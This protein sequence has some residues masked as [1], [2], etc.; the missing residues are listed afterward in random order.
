MGIDDEQS[1]WNGYWK[2]R[3][4]DSFCY[5]DEQEETSVYYLL[6]D[7]CERTDIRREKEIDGVPQESKTAENAQADVQSASKGYEQFEEY[8]CKEMQRKAELAL[9]LARVGHGKPSSE[10]HS[11]GGA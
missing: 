3:C 7:K 8:G 2:P 5:Y 11:V 9:R 6:N 4:F 10:W 1:P